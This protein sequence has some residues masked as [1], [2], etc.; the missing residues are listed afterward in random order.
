MRAAPAL[1]KTFQVESPNVTY[2]DDYITSEYD[3]SIV[4]TSLT[5]NGFVARPE[6]K[7]VHL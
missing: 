7:K 2:T 6:T 3:Y 5:E 1:A 4:R